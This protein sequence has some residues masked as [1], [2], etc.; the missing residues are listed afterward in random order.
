[1]AERCPQARLEIL[2]DGDERRALEAQSKRLGLVDRVEFAGWVSAEEGARRLRGSDVFV[3]PS[4]R[5]SGGVVLLE[6]MAVRPAGG[7]DPLGR[8][9]G[10]R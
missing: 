3:L 5:E 1:M 8:A 4:L 9:R 10:P 6:A 2:G 7:R